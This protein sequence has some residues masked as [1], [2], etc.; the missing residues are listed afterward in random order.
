ME[1]WRYCDPLVVAMRA[2]SQSCKGCEFERNEMWFG[3]WRMR[4][5][6]DKQHGQRCSQF[7]MAARVVP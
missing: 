7:K 2:E 1:R 5:T 4:C 3:E 6:K